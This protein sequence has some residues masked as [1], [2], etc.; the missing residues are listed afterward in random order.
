MRP[1]R[2][3]ITTTRSASRTRARGR[4]RAIWAWPGDKGG[5]HLRHHLFAFA[6]RLV[7]VGATQPSDCFQVDDQLELGRLQNRQVGRLLAL[8][9]S[10]GIDTGLTIGIGEARS[11]ADETAS[12]DV[13]AILIKRG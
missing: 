8:E 5:V 9:D 11:V 4:T 6:Q 10:A 12:R 2:G 13:L 1:G 3:P 7:A